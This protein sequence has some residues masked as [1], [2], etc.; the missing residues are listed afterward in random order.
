M[1][2]HALAPTRYKRSVVC[3]FVHRIFRACST[4][5]NFHSSLERAIK[6]LLNNQYPAD[7]YKPLIRS[8][9][10]KLYVPHEISKQESE[11]DEVVKHM[12]FLRYRGKITEEFVEPFT[13]WMLHANPSWPS[14]NWKLSCQIYKECR[15]RV[16]YKVS[17]PLCKA[18]YVEQ[19][20]LHY[21]VWFRGHCQ[22]SRPFGKHIRLCGVCLAF[23]NKE[24]VTIIQSTPRSIAFIETLEALWQREIRPT[25]NTKDEYR[26]RALKSNS[27]P[28]P[29]IWFHRLQ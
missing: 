29:P 20:D 26:S 1:N 3:G 16:V 6:I 11:S 14:V 27:S 28:N 13:N 4:W 9:M 22:P 18:C 19:T 25:I 17:C 10:E 23:E 8:S 12:V 5:E 2:F 21:L 24:S 7:F 15:S